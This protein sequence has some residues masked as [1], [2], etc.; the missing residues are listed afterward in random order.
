MIKYNLFWLW[1]CPAS[2]AVRYAALLAHT[3]ADIL[4]CQTMLSVV[5]LCLPFCVLSLSTATLTLGKYTPVSLACSTACMPRAYS[6]LILQDKQQTHQS[7]KKHL[8]ERTQDMK[9]CCRQALCNQPCRFERTWAG[10][11][12]GRC[13]SS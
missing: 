13:Q 4:T 1:S 9:Q 7:A 2:H 6:Y 11:R 5:P 10:T 3:Q 12:P 8:T